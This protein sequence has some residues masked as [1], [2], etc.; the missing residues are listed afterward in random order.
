M[1][2]QLLKGN[3][4]NKHTDRTSFEA[5]VNIT[6]LDRKLI[7]NPIRRHFATPKLSIIVLVTNPNIVII[8]P[9]AP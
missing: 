1:P 7:T 3:V 2:K 6:T 8:A 4:I 5:V 9:H